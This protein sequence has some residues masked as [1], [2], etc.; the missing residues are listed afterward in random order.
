LN[1]ASEKL[2]GFNVT[3]P[4]KIKV[5]NY[6]EEKGYEIAD[7]A[8][9]VESVNTVKIDSETKKMNAYNT[10]SFGFLESVVK[11][12]EVHASAGNILVFGAGGAGHAI[13]LFLAHKV[14]PKKIYIFDIDEKKAWDIKNKFEQKVKPY[15]ETEIEIITHP[16]ILDRIIS[17][18]DLIVNA[19]TVGTKE[20]DKNLFDYNLLNEK[21]YV[22]DLVYARETELLKE[23]KHKKCKYTDGLGM[24]IRQAVEA[25]VIW[26]DIDTEND[27]NARK[28]IYD[29]MKKAAINEMERRKKNMRNGILTLYLFL[30]KYPVKYNM[31]ILRKM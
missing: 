6:F 15:A 25:F 7:I 28:T 20:G 21:H 18:V 10:D 3:V 29:I 9:L 22:Y 23:A 11:D 19:T 8:K 27:A 12:L 26:N 5:K 16:E 1:N 4:Y 14:P 31:R 17:D 24:L 2:C 13:I 30:L